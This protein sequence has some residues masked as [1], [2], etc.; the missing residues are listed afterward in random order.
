M[1]IEYIQEGDYLIPNLILGVDP[2]ENARSLGKY[3]LMREA[4]L[5]KHRSGTFN[6]MLL[7]NTLKRHLLEV[8]RAARER[9]GILMDGLLEKNPAPDK[10]QDQMAWVGHMNGLK[11]MAEEVILEELVY[12]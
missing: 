1:D 10:A 8:D 9:M 6:T 5:R 4:Y 11:H 7:R 3:G 12:I 2:D